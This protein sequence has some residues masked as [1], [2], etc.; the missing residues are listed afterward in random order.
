MIFKQPNKNQP[1]EETIFDFFPT[2]KTSLFP[3]D[4]KPGNP[5]PECQWGVEVTRNPWTLK[6]IMIVGNGYSIYPILFHSIPKNS[7]RHHIPFY[8]NI[9]SQYIPIYSI[10]VSGWWWIWW[11]FTWN[12]W[13][14]FRKGFPNP[15]I[16][17]DGRRSGRALNK[18]SWQIGLMDTVGSE[19]RLNSSGQISIIPK[20][21]LRGFWGDSL[22]KPPFK[23]TSAGWSL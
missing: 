5:S 14:L 22:T 12:S 2:T 7:C 10:F 17:E 11:G 3:W 23:V 8:S 15:Q 16:R 1:F 6:N 19:I 13:S 21:E 18:K 4:G 9:W 20:P